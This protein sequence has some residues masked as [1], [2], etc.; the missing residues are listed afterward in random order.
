MPC[1]WGQEIK[2]FFF[3]KFCVCVYLINRRLGRSSAFNKCRL[4][5]WKEIR[6]G[7]EK[8]FQNFTINLLRTSTYKEPRRKSWDSGTCISIGIHTEKIWE[9]VIQSCSSFATQKVRQFFIPQTM[10][11]F[12]IVLL[13]LEQICH[14]RMKLKCTSKSAQAAKNFLMHGIQGTQVEKIYCVILG[15]SIQLERDRNGANTKVSAALVLPVWKV[16]N[17]D[18]VKKELYCSCLGKWNHHDK[19]NWHFHWEL[20]GGWQVF[21]EVS[22]S[23]PYVTS[24]P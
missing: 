22:S 4:L 24:C 16:E 10:A 17:T 6:D 2:N 13:I 14:L 3:Q 15:S 9:T 8:G 23:R 5:C 7:T 19:N 11:M 1:L 20:S 21:R 12:D 18:P